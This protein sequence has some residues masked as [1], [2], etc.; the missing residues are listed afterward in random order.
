[1]GKF[2]S[3]KYPCNLRITLQFERNRSSEAVTFISPSSNLAMARAGTKLEL[4][5]SKDLERILK[6]LVLMSHHFKRAIRFK[7]T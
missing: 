1:M 4:Y 7:F 3:P 5:P 6:M 2:V